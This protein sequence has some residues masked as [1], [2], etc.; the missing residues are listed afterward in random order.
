MF[1]CHTAWFLVPHTA[2]GQFISN[3][4]TLL[5]DIGRGLS[6]VWG[7]IT[8][9]K[10]REVVAYLIILFLLPNFPLVQQ[11]LAKAVKIGSDISSAINACTYIFIVMLHIC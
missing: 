9:D 7:S 3:F 2:R 11:L 6:A 8:L 10:L 4:Y 5:T 1:L